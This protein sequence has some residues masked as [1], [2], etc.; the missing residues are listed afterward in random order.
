MDCKV[1]N[2][3]VSVFSREEDSA[4]TQMKLL[5]CWI[6]KIQP[7]RKILI[8]NLNPIMPTD[9]AHLVLL[10][11][12]YGKIKATTCECNCVDY[13]DTLDFWKCEGLF[14]K[15]ELLYGKPF[16]ALKLRQVSTSE[17]VYEDVP[18]SFIQKFFAGRALPKVTYKFNTRWMEMY[19][20]RMKGR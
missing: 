1:P 16:K 19:S 9:D 3:N 11:D 6:R 15:Y 10:F 18:R 20:S 13:H 14:T 2:A 7:Q 4:D 17:G 12:W 8:V 5:C